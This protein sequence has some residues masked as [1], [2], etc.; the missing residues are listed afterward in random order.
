MLPFIAVLS[1]TDLS[2]LKAIRAQLAGPGLSSRTATQ[3]TRQKSHAE[4]G[5]VEEG[6]EIQTGGERAAGEGDEAFDLGA[7]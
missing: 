6:R 5:M 7:L 1:A 3:K 2:H 4:L